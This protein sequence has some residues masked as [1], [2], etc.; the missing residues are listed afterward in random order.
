MVKII[1]NDRCALDSKLARKNKLTR[2]S[3]SKVTKAKMLQL[4]NYM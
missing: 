1:L 3:V 4:K 2:E